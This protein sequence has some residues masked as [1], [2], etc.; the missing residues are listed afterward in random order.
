MAPTSPRCWWPLFSVSSK[1]ALPAIPLL[2]AA[3]Y[4][5][6]EGGAA[7]L[8]ATAYKGL[9]GWMPGGIAWM[10]TFVCAVFTTFTGAS[11]T[12]LAV[13]GLSLPSLLEDRYPED[14]SVGLVTASGSLGL[15]FPPSLPVILYA[16]VAQMPMKDLFVGGF[17]PGLL[18]IVLVAGYGVIMG[19]RAGVPR[20]PFRGRQAGLALWEAKWDLGL[21][22]VVIVAVATGFATVVEAAALAGVDL[23]AH[24]RAAGLKSI[25]PAT[26][27]ACWSTRRRWWAA[28]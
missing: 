8:L 23:L 3:G 7:R 25:R 26:C 21:P 28:C 2:T 24:R 5:L 20:V 1:E 11:V 4:I 10:A 17:L 14:F 22:T 13:G 6:A 27:R 18:M 19:V 9:F 16:V 12:I 15:L